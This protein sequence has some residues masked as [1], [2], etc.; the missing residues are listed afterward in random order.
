MYHLTQLMSDYAFKVYY[1]R[2][3][4]ESYQHLFFA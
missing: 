2:I 4:L 1:I 3:V